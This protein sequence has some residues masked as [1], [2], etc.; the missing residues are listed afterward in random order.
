VGSSGSVATESTHML[1]SSSHPQSKFDVALLS[2]CPPYSSD[3]EIDLLS[4]IQRV[5]KPGGKL[6]IATTA[7]SSVSSNLVLSGF[8]DIML[9][10]LSIIE[11]VKVF[12]LINLIIN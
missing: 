1:T 4:E 10:R 2:I 8:T 7:H 11:S 3:T 5:I 6:V 9:G 12:F